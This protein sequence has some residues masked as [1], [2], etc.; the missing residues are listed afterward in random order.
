VDISIN[1]RVAHL[2]KGRP[3]VDV[4]N[5]I[6]AQPLGKL[7]VRKKGAIKCEHV[8]IHASR[9]GSAYED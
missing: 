6:R 3:V 8:R 7:K 4:H 9:M 5:R 1:M 2:S